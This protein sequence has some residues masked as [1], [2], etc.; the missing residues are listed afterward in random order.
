[1]WQGGERIPVPPPPGS[2]ADDQLSEWSSA[3]PK[4]NLVLPDI[5]ASNMGGE[6]SAV[7][8]AVKSPQMKRAEG[9]P[10]ASTRSPRSP[11]MVSPRGVRA[12]TPPKK[13]SHAGGDAAA[14]TFAEVATLLRKVSDGSTTERRLRAVASHAADEEWLVTL[15]MALREL[16][17]LME[18]SAAGAVEHQR[19]LAAAAAEAASRHLAT[20]NG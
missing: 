14:A 10:S 9:A 17:S 7:G 8:Q 18:A 12:S 2:L 3:A 15:G 4:D 1:M 11:R 6:L 5:Y 20:V 13:P 19:Q 16:G